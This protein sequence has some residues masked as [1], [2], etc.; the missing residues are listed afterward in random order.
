MK[1]G[2]FNLRT[3]WLR[4]S[5]P[6][7]RWFNS[8]KLAE[9]SG[10]GCLE[11]WKIRLFGDRFSPWE[12]SM[13]S[14]WVFT[15]LGNYVVLVIPRIVTS[16]QIL[17]HFFQVICDGKISPDS[18]CAGQCEYDQLRCITKIVGLPPK[19]QPRGPFFC[20]MRRWGRGWYPVGWWFQ[21]HFCQFL[22]TYRG[23]WTE[24]DKDIHFKWVE[25][26]KPPSSCW[27]FRNPVIYRDFC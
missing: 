3:S 17:A 13:K 11:P 9:T 8:W 18:K 22:L 5:P 10:L 16:Q 23:R 7:P 21:T 27:W 24:F 14:P 1:S 26:L 15:L 20:W 25:T 12:M 4:G 19:E 6:S 2:G